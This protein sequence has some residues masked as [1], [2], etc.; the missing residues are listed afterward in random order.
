MNRPSAI[1]TGLG[2]VSAAGANVPETLE[3]FALGRRSAGPVT[4]FPTALACPVFECRGVPADPAAPGTRSVTLALRAAGEAIADSGMG[5][6]LPS[7]RVGVCLGTTVACQLNDLDFYTAFRARGSAPMA[8]VDRFL[9]GNLAEAVARQVGAAGPCLTVVNACSS[10]T[11]AIGIAL[12]WIASGACDAVLAGGADELS[13]IPYDGFHALSVM[14][15]ALCR[16]FDR[17]RQGL[18]LGEGAGVLVMEAPRFAS[19]RGRR[20]AVELRGYGAACDA[21]HLTAPRPDG[22]G[23]EAAIRI[24]LQQSDIDPAAVDFVNAHGTATRDNDKVEGSTLFRVFGAGPSVLS[25]KGYTG[26]ALGAAGGLEAAFAVLA[27][28]EGWLPASAGFENQD[29]EI[30]LAALRERTPVRR[31]CAVSTSLAFGGNN[32]ALVFRRRAAREGQP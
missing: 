21:Y 30:P 13:R 23:L 25:T 2:A 31:P 1:I 16:P 10:G 26:H 11:D 27:L 6:A 14:S 12:S 9:K 5:N 24:A 7:D 8:A 15:P 28:R 22:S 17:D 29:P 32:A 19:A 3:S 20:A 18:N 4:L